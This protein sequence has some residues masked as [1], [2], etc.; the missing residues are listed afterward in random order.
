MRQ[1]RQQR[2]QRRPGL[3]PGRPPQGALPPR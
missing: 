3:P 2:Q 1:Q